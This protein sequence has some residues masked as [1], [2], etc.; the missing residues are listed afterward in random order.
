MPPL[1]TWPHRRGYAATF[2]TAKTRPRRSAVARSLRARQL[3]SA[4]EEGGGQVVGD[5]R[6][7]EGQTARDPEHGAQRQSA[8]DELRAEDIEEPAFLERVDEGHRR[9]QEQ[10]QLGEVQQRVTGQL[11]DGCALAD[12]SEADADEDP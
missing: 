10:Q 12:T 9:D 8:R 2:S 6:D 1:V 11:T 7:D 3:S 5:R 4:Q